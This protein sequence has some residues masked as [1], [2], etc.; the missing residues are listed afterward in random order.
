MNGLRWIT[1]A[2]MVPIVFIL[3]AAGA[4]RS[5]QP[6]RKAIR[7]A[8]A[9]GVNFVALWGMEPFAERHGLRIEMVA[10]MSNADQ[11]RRI[12]DWRRRGRN[13]GVSEPRDHGGAEC[14]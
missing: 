11:Q 9:R 8:S 6:D 10:A 14:R 7:I 1:T 13:P 2:L 3:L 5:Q 12:A 4:V